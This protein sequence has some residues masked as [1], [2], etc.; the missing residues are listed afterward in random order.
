LFGDV[1]ISG[2][3][4][5]FGREVACSE[6]VDFAELTGGKPGVSVVRGMGESIEK[7]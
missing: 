6:E 5:G 7:S 3:G 2:G 4:E 1:L